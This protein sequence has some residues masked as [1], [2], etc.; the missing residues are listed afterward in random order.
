MQ[1]PRVKKARFDLEVLRAAVPELFDTTHPWEGPRAVAV[2]GRNAQQKQMQQQV[3]DKTS[4]PMEEKLEDIMVRDM[5]A[6]PDRLIWD[7]HGTCQCGRRTYLFGQCDKCARLEADER[8]DH[9]Q[10]EADREDICPLEDPD[11]PPPA[12]PRV[13]EGIVFPSDQWVRSVAETQEDEPAWQPVSD[14]GVPAHLRVQEWRYGTEATIPARPAGAPSLAVW[15]VH[16][17]GAVVSVVEP[18]PVGHATT[19]I[20]QWTKPLDQLPNLTQGFAFQQLCTRLWNSSGLGL[21]AFIRLV[22]V[23][24]SGMP[25]LRHQRLGT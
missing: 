25:V 23:I 14:L 16:E 21:D 12:E 6:E 3:Y 7:H 2:L 10:E 9:A 4:T 24:V 1:D 13:V 19:V 20:N 22:L 15:A 18:A 11:Q 8:H 17:D 5:L